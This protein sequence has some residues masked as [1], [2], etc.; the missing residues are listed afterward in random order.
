M[1]MMIMK[2][3]EKVYDVY[4]DHGKSLQLPSMRECL[5][6]EGPG[7]A[8]AVPKLPSIQMGYSFAMGDEARG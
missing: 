3:N 8:E 2:V 1:M 5:D 4:D 7:T 6:T